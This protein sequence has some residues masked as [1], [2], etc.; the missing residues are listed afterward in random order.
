MCVPA[1][2][3]YLGIASGETRQEQANTHPHHDIKHH[4]EMLSMASVLLHI[5]LLA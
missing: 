5:Q 4:E 1:F 2:S 3:T